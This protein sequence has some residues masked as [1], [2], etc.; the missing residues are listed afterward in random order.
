MLVHERSRI[1]ERGEGTNEPL[2]SLPWTAYPF[3]VLSS[4]F[5]RKEC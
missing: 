4:V 1:E 2:G 3:P 5:T